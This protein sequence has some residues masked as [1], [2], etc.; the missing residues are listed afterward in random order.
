MARPRLNSEKAAGGGG[1]CLWTGGDGA[2]PPPPPATVAVLDFGSQ[3]AHLI[4]RRCREQRVYAELFPPSV[5]PGTLRERGVRSVILSGGPA[6]VYARGAPRCDPGILDLGVP[7]LGICY[8]AQLI[9]HL[10]CE[11][12]ARA[13][14]REY[15]RTELEIAEEDALFRGLGP[16]TT[17]WM[18][19]GDRIEK[20]PPGARVLARTA[21]SPIA[22][23]KLEGPIVRRAQATAEHG[24]PDDALVASK[25]VLYG[26]QFHPEV[27][28]TVRGAEILK[29]FLFG[30][31]RLS[32]DWTPEAFVERAVREAREAAGPDRLVCG[33]SGGVDS[34]VAALLVH[35][36]LPGR[37]TPIFVD[38]GL[39]RKGEPEAVKALATK[40]G[41][42][43]VFVDA[44]QRFLRK[45]RGVSDP[46]RKRRIIG[47]EFVRVFEERAR[48]IK[49]ARWLV[50]GTIYPDRIE[51]A[52]TSRRASRI[53]THHNVAGLPAKMG[54][55]VLE[56][57][58][59][60]Y[61]DEVRQV[62]RALG[63]PD[64]IVN[65]HPFPGPGLAARVIGEA[66]EEKLRICRE[67]G[68]IVEEE[69]QKAG[70]YGR[71]WQAFAV[72]GDDRATGVL[73]DER[74]LGRIV[75]V[76]VVESEEAMTADWSR[77]P[78]ELLE[79]I[80]N[81]IT[82]EVRGVTWVAYA[83]SSKPPATI[84]PC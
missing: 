35:R 55:K 54:L 4:A 29:N 42:K 1:A 76:R 31:C 15:G 65:R 47:E 83:I 9:A 2:P 82:N 40:V 51:S 68:A 22:A 57:L 12:V 43:L 19:H 13:P 66:T 60:L 17:V 67:A 20:L 63:L 53:K 72:V 41:L 73:G 64:E 44:R 81:R 36:A 11:G 6:S 79:A 34:T 46:E 25:V 74:A 14:M 62:G 38:H 49:G 75:V 27:R 58:R 71:V 5:K 45:L 18:S 77:L 84:E 21:H 37:L 26:I 80:S 32:P 78:P 33:L 59:D 52:A 16:R 3:Y 7:V 39:C 30:V 50:Q 23:F 10:A 48:R 56:P 69:L 24:R 8:G 28:H 70:W 61:K